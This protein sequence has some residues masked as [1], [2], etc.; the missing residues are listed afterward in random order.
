MKEAVEKYIADGVARNLNAES[1]KKMR[2]AVER[3][4]LGFCVKSG[5]RLL[6]QLGVDEIREFRN[7][8]VKKYAASSAQTRL[9]YVRGFLRFCQNSGWISAN[10]VAAVKPPKSNSS[11]TLPFEEVEIERMLA[12]ADTFTVKGNFGAGNRKR[13]RAMILLLRYSGLRI[14]DAST[15]ERVRLKGTKLFLY[16][17]KTGTPV[18]VPLPEHVVDALTESPS[19]DPKHFFWNG[20]SLKTSAVKIWET[21]FK[22]VFEK[23]N[24]KGGHIHRFRDT[25]A[26]RLLEKGVSIETVSVLLGHSNIGITLKHYRP[27]VK[28]LQEK[29]EKEVALAWR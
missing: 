9:E 2:D 21:T 8:L 23:A 28:S 14:S 27:W 12:A 22:T 13:V 25:F 1:V 10:P 26:V 16:T 20:S 19:D 7:S 15:L 6:K 18:R 4:F 11:P 24:I 3:L 5:Y 29:L 17:Q